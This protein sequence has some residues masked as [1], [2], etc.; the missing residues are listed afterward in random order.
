[1]PQVTLNVN[2]NPYQLACNEG[3]EAQLQDLASVISQR[4]GDISQAM[5]QVGEAKLILMAALTLL[6]EARSA[7]AQSAQVA[8]ETHSNAEA[9]R[10]AAAA[11]ENIADQIETT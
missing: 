11:I 2:G 3:E 7:N 10:A 8:E 5:G 4:V 9:I 6:D 1:V